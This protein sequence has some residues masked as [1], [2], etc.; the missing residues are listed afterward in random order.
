MERSL[1]LPHWSAFVIP[2][3]DLFLDLAMLALGVR[4]CFLTQLEDVEE[5]LSWQ[6]QETEPDPGQQN[7]QHDRWHREEEVGQE[8]ETGFGMMLI[9]ISFKNQIGRRSNKATSSADARCIRDG[10]AEAGQEL[11]GCFV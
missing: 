5:I 8:A 7:H 9:V 3:F 10:Y 4:F 1:G 6:P 11:S 2:L